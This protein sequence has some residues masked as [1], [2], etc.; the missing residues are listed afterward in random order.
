MPALK[1]PKLRALV[2]ACGKLLSR[3]ELIELKAGR[4]KP[5]RRNQE[6]LVA[7][8]KKLELI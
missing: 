1:K 2:K 5:H 7:I 8:L 3:R 6:L 4:S